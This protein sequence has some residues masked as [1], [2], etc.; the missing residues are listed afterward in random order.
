MEL[1]SVLCGSLDGKGVWGRMDTC[2]YILAESL[3]SSPETITTLL[4]GYTSIQNKKLKKC[5]YHRIIVSICYY[6]KH[7]LY[8]ATDSFTLS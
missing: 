6:L 1:C 4:T 5:K 2:I 8:S 3:C 7:T